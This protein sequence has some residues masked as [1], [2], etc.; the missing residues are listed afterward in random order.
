MRPD[1]YR[2]TPVGELGAAFADL[3]AAAPDTELT[4]ARIIQADS[5]A[6]A[7]RNRWFKGLGVAAGL[8]AATSLTVLVLTHV[9]SSNS[10]SSRAEDVSGPDYGQAALSSVM[11]GSPMMPGAVAG[12]SVPSSAEPASGAGTGG[13]PGGG[14]PAPA[15]TAAQT[16][17][18][19]VALP[20][21]Q[22]AP[23]VMCVADLPAAVIGTGR[24]GGDGV[25]VTVTVAS[26]SGGSQS[27]GPCPSPTGGNGV[28]CST[29]SGHPDVQVLRNPAGAAPADSRETIATLGSPSRT[30]TVDVLR[31][32]NG[33]LMPFSD[34]RLANLLE[35]LAATP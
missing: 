23:G 20:E 3:A 13:A 21:V 31:T 5:A 22:V 30:L 28:S 27:S 6:R 19:L 8:V 26:R 34:E 15:L 10:A 9:G 17:V 32:A 16:H 24:F 12:G 11:P 33:P 35:S 2:P 18:V 29:V 14:C 25:V 1:E 7:G 4:A